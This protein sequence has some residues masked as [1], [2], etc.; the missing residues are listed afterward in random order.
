MEKL[1]AYS[2]YLPAQDVYEL[3]NMAKDRKAASFVRDA[4]AAALHNKDQYV[5]GYQ[6]GLRDACKI[7]Q[8]TK[9]A[10]TLLLGNDKLGDILVEN[11]RML[12]QNGK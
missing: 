7:I 4:I 2:L 5:S 8:D 10:Y 11:I 3:R 9:E 1:I 12:E 6:K